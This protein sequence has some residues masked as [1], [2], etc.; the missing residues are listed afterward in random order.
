MVEA[1]HENAVS[2][3]H[4]QIKPAA[5]QTKKA[6]AGRAGKKRNDN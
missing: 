3:P 5:T 2:W 4:D 1:K 6:P